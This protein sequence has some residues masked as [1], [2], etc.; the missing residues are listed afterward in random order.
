[1]TFAAMLV[2]IHWLR[3]SPLSAV[4]NRFDV[5]CQQKQLMVLSHKNLP[6]FARGQTSN[7]L[8]TYTVVDAWWQLMRR[9]GCEGRLA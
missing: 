9:S 3:E 1:M 6:L 5:E 8:P 2:L 4:T 7:I